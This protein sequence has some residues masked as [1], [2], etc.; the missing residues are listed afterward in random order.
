MMVTVLEGL[1]VGVGWISVPFPPNIVVNSATSITSSN[2]MVLGEPWNL[3]VSDLHSFFRLIHVE[4]AGTRR[5][6]SVQTYRSNIFLNC[7]FFFFSS[8]LVDAVVVAFDGPAC[9]LDA[10]SSGTEVDAADFL[11]RLAGG[12][13]AASSSSS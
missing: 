3:Q 10:S 8:A 9:E 6:W 1:L 5:R 2:L 4:S 11:A 13:C 12:G 7:I